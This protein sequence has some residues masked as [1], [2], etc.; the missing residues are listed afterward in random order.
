MEAQEN[1][2]LDTR[3]VEITTR[4]NVTIAVSNALEANLEEQVETKRSYKAGLKHQTD[5]EQIE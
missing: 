1:K 5:N 2:N 4:K 3:P